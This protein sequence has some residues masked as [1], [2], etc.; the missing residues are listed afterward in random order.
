MSC[1]AVTSGSAVKSAETPVPPPPEPGRLTC[2]GFLVPYS[3]ARIASRD[4]GV[5]AMIRREGE[6]VKPGTTLLELEKDMANLQVSQQQ[7][8]LNLRET[9]WKSA[10]ELREKDVVSENELQEKLISM[11][12]ASVQ[13]EQAR[14]LLNRRTVSAPFAGVVS[15]RLREVGEAVDEFTPVLVLVQVDWLAL[16]AFLPSSR[17]RD[18]R[19]GQK[20]RISIP[21]LPGKSFAGT[22]AHVAPVV[23]AASGE[24]KIRVAIPN[25][26]GEL[27][28]GMPATAEIDLTP[29]PAG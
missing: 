18:V 20:V 16:E 7:H 24:F 1:L 22:V 19:K 23:N 4:Q 25:P 11:R 5:I 12:V 8:I 6:K 21:A 15:E 13:L 29:S 26:D 10:S 14:E 2:Q 3:Q 9:E 27:V 28:A 17:I